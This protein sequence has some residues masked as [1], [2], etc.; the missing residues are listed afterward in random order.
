MKRLMVLVFVLLLI[1]GLSLSFAAFASGSYS[2]GGY[3]VVA[4]ISS[5]RSCSHSVSRANTTPSGTAKCYYTYN[6]Q[7]YVANVPGYAAP[8]SG[9]WAAYKTLADGRL[10][11]ATTRSPDGYTVTDHN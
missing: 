7:T 5:D 6:G 4:N 1:L 10:Y 3:Y 8:G 11:K 2:P 9:Y